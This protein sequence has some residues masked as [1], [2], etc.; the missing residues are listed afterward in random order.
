MFDIQINLEHIFDQNEATFRDYLIQDINEIVSSHTRTDNMKPLPH[1]KLEELKQSIISSD[2]SRQYQT[3]PSQTLPSQTHPSQ[4]LPSQTH[5]SSILS[6]S[7]KITKEST[8]EEE[9]IY[10][11]KKT[12][13]VIVEEKDKRT[14]FEDED[15]QTTHFKSLSS[16][17]TI[18]ELE[19]FVAQDT[20][21]YSTKLNQYA[22]N[23]ELTHMV[24]KKWIQNMLHDYIQF[25][26]RN[27]ITQIFPFTLIS[28]ISSDFDVCDKQILFTS[29]LI[30]EIW[31]DDNNHSPCKELPILQN[32]NGYGFEQTPDGQRKVFDC[33]FSSSRLSPDLI[34]VTLPEII[35]RSISQYANVID[36]F[37]ISKFIP[38]K[39]R[40]MKHRR[41]LELVVNDHNVDSDR[42]DQIADIILHEEETGYRDPQIFNIDPK[43]CFITEKNQ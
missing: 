12:R 43:I 33:E 7:Q 22:Q 20:Q 37:F 30:Y 2:T 24:M 1:L 9:F 17:K 26:T 4:T 32:I 40:F 10:Q 29:R 21:N 16:F 3:L 42:L 28:I 27:Q 8:H 41:E 5:P 39:T 13:R 6:V 35:I 11:H 38:F 31:G 34:I 25:R 15:N 19:I 18:K 23:I 14:I 36:A